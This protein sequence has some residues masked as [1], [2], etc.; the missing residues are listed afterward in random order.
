MGLAPLRQHGADAPLPQGPPMRL[1]II[2]PVALHPIRAT[3]EPRPPRAPTASRQA[4]APPS[5]SRPRGPLGHR[6]ARGVYCLVCHD[7]SDSDPCAPSP[8]KRMPV[9]TRRLANRGRL[10][11]GRATGA[12]NTGSI[13]AQRPSSRIGLAMNTPPL[14]AAT[15]RHTE[16][17]N[18]DHPTPNTKV[19]LPHA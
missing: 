15:V 8:T 16:K 1:G 9:S 17:T 18:I 19:L 12:G 2:G 7:R 10:P 11:F 6:L 13:N 14:Q 4:D 3:A 5:P